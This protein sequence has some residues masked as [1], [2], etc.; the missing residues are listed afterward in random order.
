MAIFTLAEVAQHKDPKDL[1]M[2]IHDKVYDVTKFLSE[3]R[4]VATMNQL[5]RE[6]SLN[7]IKLK[8]KEHNSHCEKLD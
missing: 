4:D 3:V 6:R 7:F 1:W 5:L 8:L 2:V